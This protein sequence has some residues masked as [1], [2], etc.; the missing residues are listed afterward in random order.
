MKTFENYRESEF[1]MVNQMAW[2]SELR[3]RNKNLI[4]MSQMTLN[5]PKFDIEKSLDTV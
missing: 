4:E 3:T 2:R 1:S 5:D